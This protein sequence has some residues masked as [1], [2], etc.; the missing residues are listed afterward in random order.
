MTELIIIF[1]ALVFIAGLVVLVNPEYIFGYLR[2]NFEKPAVH[3]LAVVVRLA[4]GVLLILQ[5]GLSKYPLA[6]EILGWLSIAAALS[7]IFMGRSNFL[8]LMSWALNSL[9]RYSRVGGVLAS[10]FGA[11]L[12]YAFV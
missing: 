7:I 3:V 8:R 5:A 9:K 11:F 4:I 2:R 10:V 1:G 12:V 6:I